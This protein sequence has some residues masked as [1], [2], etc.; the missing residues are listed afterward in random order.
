MARWESGHQNCPEVP[1]LP[2]FSLRWRRLPASCP[3]LHVH[4]L[5]DRGGA[6]QLQELVGSVHQVLVRLRQRPQ[7]LALGCGS[8]CG[9]G[10]VGEAGLTEQLED[11]REQPTDRVCSGGGQGSRKPEEAG[12]ER[13]RGSWAG[14]LQAAPATP[15]HACLPFPLSAAPESGVAPSSS[16]TACSCSRISCAG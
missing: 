12:W 5:R 1:L 16:S 8:W 14:R 9:L 3:S 6:E 10:R 2:L 15:H 11:C 4:A 13:S 7:D